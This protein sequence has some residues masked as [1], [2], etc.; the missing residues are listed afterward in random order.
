MTFLSWRKFDI[1]RHSLTIFD[2]NATLRRHR[3]ERYMNIGSGFGKN[4]SHSVVFFVSALCYDA[5]ST[6]VSSTPGGNNPW[7]EIEHFQR[8]PR[9]RFD[10]K[11]RSDARKQDEG[12]IHLSRPKKARKNW[13]DW[14]PLAGTLM[15]NSGSTSGVMCSRCRTEL[16]NCDESMFPRS[17]PRCQDDRSFSA[18]QIFEAT[19]WHQC[20]VRI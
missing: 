19:T 12:G 10:E 6:P 14:C 1:S 8:L 17:L 20:S 16:T 9:S 11:R 7:G 13:R 4:A 15:K 18:E 2:V 3:V 5:K